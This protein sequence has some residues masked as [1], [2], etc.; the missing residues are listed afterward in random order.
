[1]LEAIIS[2]KKEKKPFC[3]AIFFY[4]NEKHIHPKQQATTL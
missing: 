4:L 2:F 3:F 1:M